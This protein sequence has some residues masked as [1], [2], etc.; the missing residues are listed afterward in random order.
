M[1]WFQIKLGKQIEKDLN[2]NSINNHTKLS[3]IQNH[4]GRKRKLLLLLL[5]L[6]K[7]LNLVTAGLGRIDVK[8]GEKEERRLR[9]AEKRKW[10]EALRVKHSTPSRAIYA[11]KGKED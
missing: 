11:L 9:R 8:K 10:I 5:L 6:Y 4:S 1:Q 7:D 2:F 3:T